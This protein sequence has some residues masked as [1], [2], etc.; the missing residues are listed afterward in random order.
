MTYTQRLA[1]GV[2]LGT[3]P[4]LSACSGEKTWYRPWGDSS[5]KLAQQYQDQLDIHSRMELT[6]ATPGNVRPVVH[7]TVTNVGKRNVKALRFV[8]TA[9]PN[10]IPVSSAASQ[11]HDVRVMR[12]LTSPNGESTLLPKDGGTTTFLV[13]FNPIVNDTNLT[14]DNIATRLR[15]TEIEFDK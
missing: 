8:I 12:P 2:L 5:T 9:D 4:F 6:P 7:V 10:G 14:P 1:A 11:Y 13:E 15:L 3:V